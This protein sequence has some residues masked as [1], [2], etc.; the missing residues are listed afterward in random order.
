MSVLNTIA[1]VIGYI[2]LAST[3]IV[4]ALAAWEAIASRRGLPMACRLGL[5]TVS[6]ENLDTSGELPSMFL[7]SGCGKALS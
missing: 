3:A 1:T 4:A 7:C 6:P 5:H 2:C